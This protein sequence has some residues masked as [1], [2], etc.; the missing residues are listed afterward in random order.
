MEL[1]PD[2]QLQTVIKALTDVV[3]PAVD[4]HNQLA[5]EQARLAIGVLQMVAQHLPLMY[6]YDRDELA[7]LLALA[8]T[9]KHTAAELPKAAAALH[10]IAA[11]VER[12][13][14]V[15]DRARADPC[16]L[17]QANAALRKQLGAWVTAV[18]A[19]EDFNQLK[20]IST[21]VTAHAREQ[22]LRERAW[23]VAQGWE[24]DGP[25]I[26]AIETLLAD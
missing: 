3:L 18:Y 10:M 5:L 7:R 19:G 2:F 23:L 6:R 14:H 25:A 15:L 1:R 21:A 8:N 12:G 24:G 26:P 20:P 17:H 4:V 9:L 22:L 16:E 11:S 13:G